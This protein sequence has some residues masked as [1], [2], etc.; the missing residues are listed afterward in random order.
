MVLLELSATQA[1]EGTCN[2][3]LFQHTVGVSSAMAR[4]PRGQDRAALAIKR[5]AEEVPVRGRPSKRGGG[6]GAGRATS[7]TPGEVGAQEG[8]AATDQP[9]GGSSD[10]GQTSHRA[11]M[12]QEKNR[13][14]Q[15]RFR[16]RQKAKVSELLV[17]V[18][19]LSTRIE[20]LEAEKQSLTNHSAILQKVLSMKEE[21]VE[22][23]TQSLKARDEQDSSA[24]G[25]E[26]LEILD[27]DGA[28]VSVPKTAMQDKLS[29]I[30][31]EYVNKLAGCLV[32]GGAN[33]PGEDVINTISKLVRDA[34]VMYKK[35]SLFDAATM[36]KWCLS[37]MEDPGAKQQDT[38]TQMKWK[39]IVRSLAL[40]GQ[41]KEEVSQLK[42]MRGERLMELEKEACS[43]AGEMVESGLGA[44]GPLTNVTGT[45]LSQQYIKHFDIVAKLRDNVAERSN[46]QLEF[47]STLFQG[48]FT[49][50]QMARVMVQSYPL[51]PD[52]MALVNWACQ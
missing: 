42:K 51:V 12:L 47:D 9:D 2:P 30:W 36:R 38:E 48:I 29:K 40:T 19:E 37:N 32:E 34:V 49:P 52:S 41:Q 22:T 3:Q 18:E 25:N 21:Q 27:S 26:A 1:M 11:Q 23:M 24:R 43:L 16:E 20:G 15:R 31:R 14:A 5:E 46:A 33:N 10:A 8:G 35:S 39:S 13:R 44:S 6:R 28:T 50:L 45:L 4:D 17:E 7:A